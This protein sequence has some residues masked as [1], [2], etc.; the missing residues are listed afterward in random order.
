MLRIVIPI[1]TSKY[2]SHHIP[3]PITCLDALEVIVGVC[4]LFFL[5]L[6]LTAIFNK[7]EL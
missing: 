7:G 3:Q 1:T 4:L 5:S 2:S 6:I